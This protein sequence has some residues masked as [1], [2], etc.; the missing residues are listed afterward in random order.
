MLREEGIRAKPFHRGLKNP[1]LDKTM[2]Q[3][4]EGGVE[5]VVLILEF[6]AVESD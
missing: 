5:C 3:W 1:E 2:Q 4:L 6:R